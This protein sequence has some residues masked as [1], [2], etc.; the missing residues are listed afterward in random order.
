MTSAKI[1]LLVLST[2]TFQIFF[3]DRLNITVMT[4]FTDIVLVLKLQK[5]HKT[6]NIITADI[7]GSVECVLLS[8]S[9][10]FFL[11]HMHA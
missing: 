8:L 10:V 5:I 11:H 1:R 3:F 9:K 2:E 4:V 7:R 6:E